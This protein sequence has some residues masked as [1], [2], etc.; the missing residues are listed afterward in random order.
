MRIPK[1]SFVN[2]HKLYPNTSAFKRW[3]VLERFWNK[4]L[5]IIGVRHLFIKLDWRKD[6]VGDMCTIERRREG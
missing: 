5:W 4:Q 1:I 2:Y 6:W 3:L